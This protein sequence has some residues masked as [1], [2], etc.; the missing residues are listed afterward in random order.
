MNQPTFERADLILYRMDRARETL[1][2][3][4]LLLDRGGSPGSIINR[5]Y[6]SMFYSVLALLINAGEGA[7]KHSGVIALFDRLFVKKGIF[8]TDMSKALHKAFDLRQIGDYRELIEI[9]IAQAEEVYRM[10][11]QFLKEVENYLPS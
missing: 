5:A 10:A 4:R 11:E 6:Y 3:T 8:P 9:N 2:D 1:E 7:S